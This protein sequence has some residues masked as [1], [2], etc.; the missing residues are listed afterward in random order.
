MNMATDLFN[1]GIYI[2]GDSAYAIRS[3]LLTPYDGAKPGSAEDAF[4]FYLSSMRIYVECAFGEID[5]RWGIFW[6]PLEGSLKRHQDTIDAALRLHNFI[7]NYR[8]EELN[9]GEDEEEY[10]NEEE[11]NQASDHFMRNNPLTLLGTTA[12]GSGCEGRR[13]GRPTTEVAACADQ[14]RRVR[15]RLCSALQRKKLTRPK[16]KVYGKRDRHNRVTEV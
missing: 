1:K 8:E 9:S 15:D 14:G 4:N 2:V 7:I 12:E 10:E 11:L 3:Y 5:R 6:K 13:R 16:R